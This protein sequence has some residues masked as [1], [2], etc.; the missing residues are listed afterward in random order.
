[1]GVG[2]LR[3]MS[4]INYNSGLKEEDYSKPELLDWKNFTKEL[5]QQFINSFS[6]KVTGS[7]FGEL[8]GFTL[9]E[10]YK[11]IIVHPFWNVST[12]QPEENIL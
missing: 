3:L 10:N 8:N 7:T 11:V 1:M 2:L 9:Y 4:D 12:N 5:Q 6:E